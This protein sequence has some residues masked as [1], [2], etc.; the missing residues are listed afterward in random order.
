MFAQKSLD[1][2]LQ[3]L[4]P[5]IQHPKYQF[6]RSTQNTK[7]RPVRNTMRQFQQIHLSA[8][9]GTNKRSSHSS[10]IAEFS[11]QPQICL[12]HL[13]VI[14]SQILTFTAP[15]LQIDQI[16]FVFS[17]KDIFTSAHFLDQ[18]IIHNLAGLPFD[19]NN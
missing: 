8:R 5:A 7:V 12:H 13:F 4:G 2:C 17:Q 1:T 11:D 18:C 19:D 16:I 10:L 3:G 15:S 6:K 14:F 9:I